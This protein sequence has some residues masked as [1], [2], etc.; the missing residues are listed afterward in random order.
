MVCLDNFGA[1]FGVPWVEKGWKTLVY[2]VD[3]PTGIPTKPSPEYKSKATLFG[4][5]PGSDAKFNQNFSLKTRRHHMG[6]LAMNGRIFKWIL[7]N[8]QRCALASVGGLVECSCSHSSWGAKFHRTYRLLAF[9]TV[10][11][12][13]DVSDSGNTGSGAY[14]VGPRTFEAVLRRKMYA[15][16]QYASVVTMNWLLWSRTQLKN[17]GLLFYAQ[18]GMGVLSH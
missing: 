15:H 18:W 8:I 17:M 1:L 4:S 12:Y 13:F 9:Q 3:A 7:N 11:I 2:T 14:F 6:D 5:T 10:D 16:Q